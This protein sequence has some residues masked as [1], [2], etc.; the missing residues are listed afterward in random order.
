ME[1]KGETRKYS[2]RS[3]AND[4]N[5]TLKNPKFNKSSIDL[6]ESLVT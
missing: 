1:G 6:N 2:L 4:K 5:A 3:E